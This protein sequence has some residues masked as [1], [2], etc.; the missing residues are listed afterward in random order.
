MQLF[1]SLSLLH[2]KTDVCVKAIY[3]F[4]FFWGGGGGGGG[5][6]GCLDYT[7]FPVED[8]HLLINLPF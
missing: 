5:G 2:R 6:G 4:S 1:N 8:I 3:L 7:Q